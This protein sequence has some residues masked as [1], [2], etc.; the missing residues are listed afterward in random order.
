MRA[1][2]LVMAV[3][4][5]S[6]AAAA[7]RAGVRVDQDEV[8]FTLRA[9]EAQEV[10]LVGDF[11]QW[12]PTVEPMNRVD[13]RWEVGLFLVAGDYHYQFVVDGKL[14]DD[15]DN[16]ASAGTRGSPLGLIERGNALVLSTEETTPAGAPAAKARPGLRYIGAMRSRD[17]TDFTHRVDLTVRGR[18]E[19]LSGRA[20]VASEDTSWSSDPLSVDV[21]F[22]RGRVDVKAGKLSAQGF[23][24]DS[25]W[26]SLDPAQ[27]VGNAGVYDYNAGFLRHGVAGTVANSSVT[28]RALY[29]DVTTR[30]PAAPVGVTAPA[31]DDSV[32]ATRYSFD[33]SDVL[34]M[35]AALELGGASAGLV[36]RREAGANPGVAVRMRPIPGVSDDVYAT[37]ENRVA[38]NVWVDPGSI[39]GARFKAG[40]GWGSIKSHAFASSTD[41]I[42]AGAD[43][44]ASMALNE[45]DRTFPVMETHRGLAELSTRGDAKWRGLARWDYT[46]FIFDGLRGDATGDVHRVTLSAADTVA[47][48]GI[49]L[50]LMYTDA[51]YG[52]TPDALAL[53]WPELN[54]WLSIWDEFDP[55]RIVGLTTDRYNIATL[56]GGTRWQR[57]QVY[58]V[59]QAVL[60][61]IVDDV[62]HANG[63]AHI[64]AGVYGPLRAS[65]DARIAWYDAAQWTSDGALWS[66]YVETRYVRDGIELSVG[67]GFDPLVFDRVTSE[68]G[69]IGYTE[70]LRRGAL[71]QGVARSQANDTVRALI[72][73]ER[74][75]EDAAVFKIELVVDLR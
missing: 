40:Y 44:D 43:V 42:A 17:E 7:S 62:M 70:F 1:R 34:A 66:G 48:W 53:D 64:D 59:A 54:P 74:A 29:A 75:L 16:P 19:N 13:D 18:Y 28:V 35:E 30:L 73:T 32:Y 58:L 50:E 38:S 71:A 36:F 21:W 5:V 14:L 49:G 46:R 8:I 4:L 2:V 69:D 15:P 3:L 56:S 47:S 65:V 10:F 63:R 6:F 68:Y 33:A 61:G 12:N 57:A 20:A 27:L 9:P 22:D 25:T 26:T 23:E 31:G 37:R 51:H 11:N 72:E 39:F 24:N 45:T 41:S 55:A 52:A 60:E 67:F